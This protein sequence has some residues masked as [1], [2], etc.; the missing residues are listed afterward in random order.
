VPSAAFLE[1]GPCHI[2]S[3]YVQ[4]P[5]HRG[6]KRHPSHNRFVVL[7]SLCALISISI[8]Q[9]FTKRGIRI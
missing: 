4:R 3:P 8:S 6:R 5:R 1:I 2:G 9:A 7:H